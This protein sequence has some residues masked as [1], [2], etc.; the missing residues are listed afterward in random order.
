M[1]KQLFF[2]F[3]MTFFSLC[4]QNSLQNKSIRKYKSD[5]SLNFDIGNS[6]LKLGNNSVSANSSAVRI[7]GNFWF[8][9]GLNL[10]ISTGLLN[11]NFQSFI[12]DVF[13]FNEFSILKSSLNAGFGL[14]MYEAGDFKL[15]LIPQVGIYYSNY[16]DYEVISL[17]GDS[18]SNKDLKGNFGLITGF[19]MRIQLNKSV[20]ST[21]YFLR[22][23]DFNAIEFI[24]NQNLK[25]KN[26]KTIGVSI[27]YM[28]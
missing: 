7:E 23:L 15:I 17:D 14:S 24:D 16:M 11:L 6:E 1:E 2:L 9:N 28:F 20:F 19:K 3:F 21:F 10:N 27:G 22:S 4:G 25:I 13:T 5:L 18:L 26:D 8:K 12:G